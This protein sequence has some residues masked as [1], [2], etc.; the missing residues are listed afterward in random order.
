MLVHVQ[1]ACSLYRQVKTSVPGQGGQHMIEEA[2]TRVGLGVPSP[3]KN[4]GDFD[5]S[6]ARLAANRGRAC[7]HAFLSSHFAQFRN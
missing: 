2:D 4:Q 1:V 3:I 7:G 6:F 5:L